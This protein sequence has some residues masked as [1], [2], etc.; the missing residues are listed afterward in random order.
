M[1]VFQRK[2]GKKSMRRGREKGVCRRRE[3]VTNEKTTINENGKSS[4]V[5]AERRE[6]E[7]GTDVRVQYRRPISR[8][9]PKQEPYV[10]KPG[11]IT[12]N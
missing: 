4:D 5:D 8:I 11:N 3:V 9:V 12:K 10:S 2:E 1:G 6:R 7:G